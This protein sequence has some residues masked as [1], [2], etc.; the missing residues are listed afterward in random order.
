MSWELMSLRL[1]PASRIRRNNS[2]S[3]GG[4]STPADKQDYMITEYHSCSLSK[5]KN[6]LTVSYTMT[7]ELLQ[8]NI[9]Q[10]SLEICTPYYLTKLIVI[11]STKIA[12][13]PQ[14][15]HFKTLT[16]VHSRLIRLSLLNSRPLVQSGVP[17]RD[18]R[19]LLL[20]ARNGLTEVTKRPV[21]RDERE[22][23]IRHF[24]AGEVFLVCEDAV[25]DLQNTVDLRDIAAH[26]GGD[27]LGVVV[28]KPG[29][30]AEVWSLA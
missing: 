19:V 6:S 28:N 5:Q 20:P 12:Y 17:G 1:G 27:L 16:L 14:H 23:R 29:G 25:E 15:F 30:L 26:G 2:D 3:A 4:H 10:I 11:H 7:R 24:A 21:P 13:R 22:I 9:F 8:P 18:I